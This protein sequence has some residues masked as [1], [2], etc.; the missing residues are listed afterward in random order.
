MQV[1]LIFLFFFIALVYS[2]AGFGGG[3]SYLA[4][5]AL[6]GLPMMTLRPVALLCNL[7]V[8]SGNLIIFWKNGQLRWQQ[9]APLVL[10]GIPLAF[11]GG[12]WRLGERAFFLLLGLSLLAAT[13][14]MWQQN[15]SGEKSNGHAPLSIG[16]NSGIGGGLGLLAGLTGIGG[17]IFLAP[18]LHLLRWD[19]PKVIAATASLFIFCQS[20]AGLGGQM[21]QGAAID[22][23]M[24]LPLLAAVWLGGQLGARWSTRRLPQTTVR[25]LTAALVFYAGVNILWRHL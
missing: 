6:L 5:M 2:S 14:A 25:S 23:K 15:R 21:A 7:V 9:S 22:W 20:A 10:A 4:I 3:S 17:G 18:V 12:Y 24:V 8:V 19:T 13:L 16:A 11:L 1:E